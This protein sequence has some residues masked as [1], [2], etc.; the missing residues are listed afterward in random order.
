MEKLNKQYL[1]TIRN[2]TSAPSICGA[3]K[4]A[5][6]LQW[7]NFF[8]NIQLP[9]KTIAQDQSLEVGEVH[10]QQRYLVKNV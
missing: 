2:L 7:L 4:N 10:V 3:K 9:M 5:W 8:R 1:T 6:N